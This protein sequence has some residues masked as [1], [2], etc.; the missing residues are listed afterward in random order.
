MRNLAL[1]Q[2]SLVAATL[3]SVGD[4]ATTSLAPHYDRFDV[5]GAPVRVGYIVAPSSKYTLDVRLADGQAGVRV[6]LKAFLTEPG[7][8][9]AQNGGFLS[10][11]SGQPQGTLMQDSRVLHIGSNGWRLELNAR[12]KASIVPDELHVAG[13]VTSSAKGANPVSWT[14]YEV[15][16]PPTSNRDSAVVFTPEW[17]G[18]VKSHMDAAVVVKA[19]KV[20]NLLKSVR[21]ID[22]PSNGFLIAFN[23][24]YAGMLNQ[25]HVGDAVKYTVVDRLGRAPGAVNAI[26]GG[27]PLVMAGRQPARSTLMDTHLVSGYATRSA[28]GFTA[29]NDVIQ[30]VF[31]SATLPE[32]SAVMIKLGA[33]TA[34]N[35]DGGGS[36]GLECR[37]GTVA[38]V[39]RRLPSALVVKA[40]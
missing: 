3:L 18:F 19:G 26:A 6:N 27:P 31:P 21:N 15:N 5:K 36:A 40:R 39:G 11:L 24:K 10:E 28:V 23:G 34:L 16:E 2:F 1:L 8:E 35:L 4:A 38:P 25:F 14:A 13:T 7:D 29:K 37:A 32:V 22:I 9:C 12:G 30:A 33:V 20:D 17:A